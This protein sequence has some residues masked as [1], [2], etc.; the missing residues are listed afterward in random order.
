MVRPRVE[1]QPGELSFGAH[2]AGALGYST[3]DDQAVTGA[4][5][6]VNAGMTKR[7][8]MDR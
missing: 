8:S 7:R 6:F 1:G 4:V 2:V 3:A 5:M